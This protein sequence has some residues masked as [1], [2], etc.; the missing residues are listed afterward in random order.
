[1][2]YDVAVPSV[3]EAGVFCGESR[4]LRLDISPSL[5]SL[6][7]KVDGSVCPSSHLRLPPLFL[8]AISFRFIYLQTLR[9]SLAL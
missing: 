7:P 6:H 1:M 8:T 3:R 5:E 9:H 2:S 4:P